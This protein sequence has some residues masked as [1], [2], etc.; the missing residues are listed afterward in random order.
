MYKWAVDSSK[1][2]QVHTTKCYATRIYLRGFANPPHSTP[3]IYLFD[4][5][6]SIVWPFLRHII[7][8]SGEPFGG[9]HS[10]SAVSPWATIVFCGSK[11]NSSRKT[12]IE[13]YRFTYYSICYWLYNVAGEWANIWEKYTSKEEKSITG[14]LWNQLLQSF[15]NF[16]ALLVLWFYTVCAI[17]AERRSEQESLGN[18][19]YFM[20]LNLDNE[21]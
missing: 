1:G 12:E 8:G 13:I 16:Y 15:I 3:E 2:L 14:P 17:R 5:F 7:V 11:R 6:K 9:P 21:G 10:I 4:E 20:L 19:R 18:Y